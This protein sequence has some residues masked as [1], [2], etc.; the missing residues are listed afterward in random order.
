M[1]LLEATLG[2]WLR[3]EDEEETQ[4]VPAIQDSAKEA[5]GPASTRAKNLGDLGCILQTI[6]YALKSA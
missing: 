1:F 6:K 4:P 3:P 2:F 5:Q